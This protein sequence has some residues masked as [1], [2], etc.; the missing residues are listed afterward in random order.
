MS[1]YEYID[2]FDQ[3]LTIKAYE[4][5]DNS[6]TVMITVPSGQSNITPEDA[7]A[8]AL[9][10][11]E[12]ADCGKAGRIRLSRAMIALVEHISAEKERAEREAEDPKVREF[13]EASM[14][15]IATVFNESNADSKGWDGLSE[16]G[17]E[18]W[19]AR[20]RAARKFFE[21]S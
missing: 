20:Y 6:K 3:P 17:R 14:S 7:P 12:A 10:I 19:R 2:D 16:A 21:E 18:G 15:A 11:L 13:R 9:A 8:V 1:D 4:W 5:A